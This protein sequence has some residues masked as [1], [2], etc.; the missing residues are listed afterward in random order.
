MILL[1]MPPL[2]RTVMLDS[3]TSVNISEIPKQEIQQ[4]GKYHNSDLC[5]DFLFLNF[6]VVYVLSQKFIASPLQI[7]PKIL[8]QEFSSLNWILCK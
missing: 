6:A 5:L 1:Y 3:A 4:E 7:K 8:L 2:H